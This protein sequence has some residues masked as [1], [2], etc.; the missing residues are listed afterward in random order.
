MAIAYRH[1]AY[2]DARRGKL[3][4]AVDVLNKAKRA[5]VA[6]ERASTQMAEYLSELGRADDAIALLEPLSVRTSDPDTLNTLGIAYAQAHRTA[7]ARRT[8]ERVA[9]LN[10]TSS[11]PLENLGMLALDRGDLTE[12]RRRYEGAIAIDPSS[13]RAHSGRGVAA[14]RAGD[15]AGAIDAWTRAVRLDATNFEALYNL[16]TTLARGGEVSRARP[17]LEQFLRTAPPA[18]FEADRREVGRLLGR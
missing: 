6:D 11:V 17:Y 3:A 10:P 1:L 14:L 8:F 15:R 9:S 2:I 4:E 5:G 16:G 13:S 7:A 18:R 12:A